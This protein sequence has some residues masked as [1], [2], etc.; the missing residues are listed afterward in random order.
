MILVDAGHLIGS[1]SVSDNAANGPS[2]TWQNRGSS[3]L[4]Q[5][6][7]STPQDLHLRLF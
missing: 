3:T 4:L 2:G 5:G 1:G 7:L 6:P